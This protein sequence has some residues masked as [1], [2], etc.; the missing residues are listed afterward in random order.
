VRIA[1]SNVKRG[2]ESVIDIKAAPGNNVAI[3]NL[4]TQPRRVMKAIRR[5]FYMFGKELVKA[6]KA[7]I[8]AGPKTGRVYKVRGRKRRASAPGEYPANQTGN[9]RSA[10]NFSVN[11]DDEL[12]FGAQEEGSKRDA[13][14]AK[15]L[16]NGTSR[17]RARPF[18]I[19]PLKEKAQDGVKFIQT[20]VEKSL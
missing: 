11:G 16:E 12:Q 15:F 8:L 5:G 7:G 17:M 3:E 9:L 18:L 20:E 1:R 13:K 19:R 4:K 14:Y 6:S 2:G 10:I